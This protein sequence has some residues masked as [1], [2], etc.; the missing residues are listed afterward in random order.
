MCR[1]LSGLS[2]DTPTGGSVLD[3]QD[4]VASAFGLVRFSSRSAAC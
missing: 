3:S 1:T 2:L 4:M